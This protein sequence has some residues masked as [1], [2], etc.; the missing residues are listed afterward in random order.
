MSVDYTASGLS[1][2]LVARLT[3]YAAAGMCIYPETIGPM[4]RL[5]ITIRELAAQSE[6]EV[7]ILERRLATA[8]DARRDTVDIG[9]D[10]NVV[11]LP[12]RARPRAATVITPDGGDAA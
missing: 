9:P 8:R 3:Q 2:E 12:S 5:L 10:G 4:L 6:E 1:A 7:R 11:R